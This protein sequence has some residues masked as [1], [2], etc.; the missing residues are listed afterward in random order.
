MSTGVVIGIEVVVP[1]EVCVD[2]NIVVRHES[3]SCG[4]VAKVSG[5]AS[6][7]G[8]TTGLPARQHGI[9]CKNPERAEARN[10]KLGG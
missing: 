4:V 6:K 3:A 7:L 2:I 10:Q 8:G 9:D 5:P 1:V